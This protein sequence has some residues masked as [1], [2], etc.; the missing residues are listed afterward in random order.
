MVRKNSLE[1]YSTHNEGKSVVAKIFIRT[2]QNRI[3]KYMT[4]ISKNAYI[5]KLDDVVKKCNNTYHSSIEK[6]TVDVKSSRYIDSS[7]EIND[8]DPKFKI[9]DTVRILKYK[10][11]FAKGYVPNWFEDIFMTKKVNK[12][13]TN[14]INDLKGE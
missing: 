9:G 11:I 6:K 4:L 1:M 8:E 3:Y 5:D 2:L 12:S 7:K 14:V 10:N 13:V